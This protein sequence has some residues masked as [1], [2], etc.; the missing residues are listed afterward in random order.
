MTQNYRVAVDVVSFA[1]DLSVPYRTRIAAALV[2]AA[3]LNALH[4]H[5]V[6]EPQVQQ[7]TAGTRYSGASV[8]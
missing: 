4:S 6:R 3:D 2:A 1:R 5:M 7:T 8:A